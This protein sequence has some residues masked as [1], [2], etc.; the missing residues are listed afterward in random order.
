[1]L[2]R[3]LVLVDV[4]RGPGGVADRPGDLLRGRRGTDRRRAPERVLQRRS[5][6]PG[7]PVGPVVHQ[8]R[9]A[10]AGGDRSGGRRDVVALRH[11]RIGEP[12]DL[13]DAEHPLDL[14]R[15]GGR[16]ADAVDVL[17]P[18]PAVAHHLR[19]RLGDPGRLTAAGVPREEA[20]RRGA[21]EG[22]A[23]L[24]GIA[25][26]DH[27]AVPSRRK[28]G[29]GCPARSIQSSRTRRPIPISSF[30]AP[31]TVLVNRSPGCSSSSTVATGW[32][33]E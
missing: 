21:G 30:A 1:M 6:V 32:G 26:A 14:G 28:T 31:I 3:H 29:T 4:A 13:G 5:G 17:R 7:Q 16:A 10:Q 15:G 12:G 27:Q 9:L 33:V 19:A 18:E 25:G 11:H 24:H 20:R 8:H 23:V 2:L 22:D